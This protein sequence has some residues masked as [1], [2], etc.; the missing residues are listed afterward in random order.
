[1]KTKLI[2]TLATIGLIILVVVVSLT[3]NSD[4]E[5]MGDI[6]FEEGVVNV[7]YFWQEGCPHCDAQFQFFERIEDE[8]GAYFNL[9]AFEVASNADHARLLNEVADL[10]GTQ[11]R[12]VPFT[13]IGEESFTGFSERMENDFINAIR[14]GRNHDFDVFENLID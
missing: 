2:M 5:N 10:L 11:V 6:V 14:N 8:W 3:N 12:G 1:M 13:I 9:Y 4:G 7:Y